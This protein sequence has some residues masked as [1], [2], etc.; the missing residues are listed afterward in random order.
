MQSVSKA[1]ASHSK[2]IPALEYHHLYNAIHAPIDMNLNLPP[3]GIEMKFSCT[4]Q[5][6]HSQELAALDTDLLSVVDRRRSVMRLGQWYVC[7]Y[8][9]IYRTLK[10][11]ISVSETQPDKWR[12]PFR[13]QGGISE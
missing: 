2:S 13:I 12:S 11:G 1:L 10:E 5:P 3:S 6:H 7:H 4:I 8:S 9:P